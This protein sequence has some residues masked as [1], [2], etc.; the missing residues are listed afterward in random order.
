MLELDMDIHNMHLA[1]LKLWTRKLY[2]P[3][4]FIEAVV[5]RCQGRCS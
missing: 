3:H 2:L 1:A 4:D 5:R